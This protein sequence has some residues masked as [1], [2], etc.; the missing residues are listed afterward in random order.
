M[1][2]AIRK[3]GQGYWVRTLTAVCAGVT[4]L[5]AAAWAWQE[6]SAI[7]LPV[8]AW[9]AVVAA[10]PEAP[11]FT[12]GERVELVG[13]GDD[14]DA[15]PVVLGTAS[16]VSAVREGGSVAVEVGEL[17]LNADVFSP[18]QARSL[19][20]AVPAAP[21]V[22]DP[23]VPDASA[24]PPAPRP[25][26]AVASGSWSSVPIFPLIYLQA[27]VAGVLIAAGAVVVFWLVGMNARSVDF[28][29]NT[30]GEMRKVNW[31]TRKEVIGS[32]QVVIV[33]SFL[34]AAVLFAVDLGFQEFFKLVGVLQTS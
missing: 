11:A 13:Q 8:R 4:F 9:R 27:G 12:P 20:V 24:L 33:A 28:L 25:A 3:P 34:I 5:A 26:A 1:S 21:A 6:L 18:T 23:A 15:S 10:S 29:I 30:D 16:V 2:L 31:S 32:T 14:A 22:P 7:D 17:R 19:R